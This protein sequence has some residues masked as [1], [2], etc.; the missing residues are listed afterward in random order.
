MPKRWWYCLCS[1]FLGKKAKRISEAEFMFVDT[2]GIHKF[3]MQHL[4]EIYSN[5]ILFI[6][7]NVYNV[8]TVL[9]PEVSV[10]SDRFP[11][12]LHTSIAFL[13]LRSPISE[14]TSDCTAFIFI[15]YQPK[16]LQYVHFSVALTCEARNLLVVQNKTVNRMYLKYVYWDGFL[17]IRCPI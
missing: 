12:T 17:L 1:L 15:S 10:G 16:W 3:L 7:A 9:P 5:S 13:L 8:K 2:S 6:S 14:Q 11:F 4:S